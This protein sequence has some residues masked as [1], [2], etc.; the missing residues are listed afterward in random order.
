MSPT[1]RG[2]GPTQSSRR[3]RPGSSV[4]PDA[5]PSSLLRGLEFRP[6]GRVPPGL[7]FSGLAEETMGVNRSLGLAVLVTSVGLLAGAP[8]AAAQDWKGK[9]RLDG[10]VVNEK[11]EPIAKAQLA[12]KFKGKDGPTVET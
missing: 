4:S 6:G 12:F 9:A 5:S 3:R 11:G 7:L 8:P 2:P 1:R 10:K